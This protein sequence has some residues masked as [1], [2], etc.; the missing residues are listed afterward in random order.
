MVSFVGARFPRPF[1]FAHLSLG[2]AT[3]PNNIFKT[4]FHAIFLF[5]ILQGRTHVCAHY[6]WN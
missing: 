5:F 6:I 3:L 4:K 1:V 2:R